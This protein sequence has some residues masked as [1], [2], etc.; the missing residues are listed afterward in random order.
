MKFQNPTSDIMKIS[1]LLTL[2]FLI[3]KGGCHPVEIQ[4][5]EGTTAYTMQVSS[6]GFD[7]IP[8]ITGNIGGGI[9]L[10]LGENPG[11]IGT[12]FQSNSMHLVTN[13]YKTNDEK[14]S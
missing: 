3:D 8:G 13:T 12:P 6:N 5:N 11:I 7:V 9:Q 4:V 1:I 14:T 10:I 2:L